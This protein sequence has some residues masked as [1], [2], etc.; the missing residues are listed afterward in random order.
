MPVLLPDPSFPNL[1]VAR[2]AANTSHQLQPVVC[3]WSLSGEYGTGSR[4]LYYVLVAA[5]VLAR[6]SEWLRNACLAAALVIPA[7]AAI[8]A[9]VLAA[10]HVDDAIDMDIYGAFQFC[11]IGI[12]TAPAT[13]RLSKTYFNNPGRNVMFVWTMLLLAG[14]STPV[15]SLCRRR[16]PR[17]LTP[18][19][20]VSLTVE[21]FRTDSK[22]CTDDGSGQPL[23]RGAEFP[24]GKA[25]CGMICSPDAGPFSPMRT[26]ASDNINVVPAPT[27]LNFGAATLIAA[28]CCVPGILS[29]VSMWD[30]ILRTN[31]AKQFGPGDTD[32][33]ISGTNGAT[34]KGMKTVNDVIRRLL[35]LVEIPVFGGAVLALIVTGELNFWSK[36]MKYD[37]DPL[38]N[39]SQWSSIAASVFAA[40][41]SLYMLFAE[42]LEVQENLATP[43]YPA[44]VCTCLCHEHSSRSDSLSDN[45]AA[46]MQQIQAQG[47]PTNAGLGR[48][49]TS[50][51]RMLTPVR[52][53]TAPDTD[54][55]AHGLGIRPMDSGSSTGSRR[56]VRNAL[57]RFATALGTVSPTRFDDYEFRHGEATAFPQVPGE[58]NRNRRLPQIREQWGQST[59]DADD[60]LTPRGRR[61][62]ANSFH[63]TTA[64]RSNSVGPPAS[65]P[66]SPTPA[67]PSAASFLGLP[68]TSSPESMTE[69]V[70]PA[71]PSAE[72]ET[73][74]PSAERETAWPSA[75]P[76]TARPSAKSETARR[77]GNTVVTLHEGLNSPA[78]VLSSDEE[79]SQ[80]SP[81]AAASAGPAERPPP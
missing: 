17:I 11:T 22:P 73:A 81:P 35:G 39:I 9:I 31:W 78:I 29:M 47:A 25:T 24:Y 55:Q 34:E 76:E 42:G 57:M 2:D 10:L 49:A 63:G 68:T 43:A 36:A 33:L 64:S 66:E 70:F 52:T 65:S 14:L 67:R 80:T 51:A 3:A 20:L 59:L 15:S 46:N 12:L 37:T 23:Y 38:G 48:R 56:D 60:T 4:I 77:R 58:E 19:G 71:R 5:C 30:K 13:V 50:P 40:C 32:E 41:G 18:A 27:I 53:D 16:F 75:E 69:P 61:S 1:I 72:L 54:S 45:D 62:R 6:K 26:G 44:G 8:H 7:T 74:R 28:A 79:P 21:F